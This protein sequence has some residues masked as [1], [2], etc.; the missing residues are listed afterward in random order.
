M[1]LPTYLVEV[2]TVQGQ[3]VFFGPYPSAETAQTVVDDFRPRIGSDEMVF[4]TTVAKDGKPVGM[5]S[6]TGK[7]IS[8]VQ[9]IR[10]ATT[11][12]SSGRLVKPTWSRI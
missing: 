1:D 12:R 5:W 11:S 9:V 4:S 2:T 3:R 7:G 6:M 8:D 10:S